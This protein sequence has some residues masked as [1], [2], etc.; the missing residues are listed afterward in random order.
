M[1]V[2]NLHGLP[3]RDC[4]NEQLLRSLQCI[5]KISSVG[6]PGDACAWKLRLRL[7]QSMLASMQLQCQS[8][9][10]LTVPGKPAS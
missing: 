10:C 3:Q 5:N 6:A 4:L 2:G 9:G 1:L 8:S 7:V